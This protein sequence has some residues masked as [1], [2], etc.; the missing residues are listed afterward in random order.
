MYLG[1]TVYVLWMC[2]NLLGYL[3]PP[4][5]GINHDLRHSYVKLLSR[6]VTLAKCPQLSIDWCLVHLMCTFPY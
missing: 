1:I 6:M 2:M 5:N 3:L 4:K